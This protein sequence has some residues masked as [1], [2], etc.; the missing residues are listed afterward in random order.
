MKTT[1]TPQQPAIVA[2]ICLYGTSAAGSG[3]IACI[4]DGTKSGKMI[5]TGE[6]KPGRS[7]TEAIWLAADELKGAGVTRGTVRIFES[8]GNFCAD[9]EI[10]Q[11]IGYSGS[12]PWKNAPRFA[13]SSEDLLKHATVP[14]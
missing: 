12:L 9:V 5:G 11:H 2:E 14:A 10:S 1:K 6:L 13:I 8:N 7:M 3:W 4:A